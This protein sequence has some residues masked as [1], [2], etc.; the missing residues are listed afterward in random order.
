MKFFGKKK[1]PESLWRRFSEEGVILDHGQK[2]EK[3]KEPLLPAFLDQ[4]VDEGLAQER[5]DGCIIF[6]SDLYEALAKEE[7]ADLTKTLKLPPLTTRR[8]RLESRGALTDTDF[9]IFLTGWE[10]RTGAVLSSGGQ[11]ELMSAEAWRLFVAAREFAKRSERGELFQRQSWGTI[12]KLAVAAGASLDNFLQNTVVLTPEKLQISLEKIGQEPATADDNAAIVITPSFTDAPDG[13]LGRFDAFNAVQDRYDIATK[14]GIVQVLVTP[15]VKTVLREIKRLPKRRVR[16]ARARA[17]LINPMAALGDEAGAI[18]DI[19]Q[20]EAAR[21]EAGIFHECFQPIIER[22]HY[23]FPRRVGLV[24]ETLTDGAASSQTR[25]LSDEA[26]DEGDKKLRQFIDDLTDALEKNFPL[27]GWQG[28]E[29]ELSGEAAAHRD[30]LRAALTERRE[31][32]IRIRYEDIHNLANYIDRIEGI[33]Q[34]KAY[35]S[36]YIDPVGMGKPWIPDDP[37]III[38]VPGPDGQELSVLVPVNKEK[39]EELKEAVKQAEERGEQQITL[40]WLPRPLTREEAKEIIKTVDT[41]EPV[42]AP[43]NGPSG[44]DTTNTP[45]PTK[46][47]SLIIKPNINALDYEQRR[48]DVARDSL[49]APPRRAKSLRQEITL[50]PHQEA[51]LSWL[52][53]MRRERV[54]SNIH[55][56]IL[57]DDMGLGKTL[58][59]LAFMAQLLEDDSNIAPMLVVAPVALLENW[60]E[61]VKK[62]FAPDA[63]PILT[64]YGSDLSALRLS[65]AQIDARLRDEDGLNSFLKP[66]WADGAKIVLTTYETLRNLEFSFALQTWSVM[67]CDEAQKIKNPNALMTRAAKKQRAEFKIACTGTPVENT[68]ADLW[69][70]FDFIQPGLLGALDE[71]GKKYRKPIE[72]KTEEEKA[73]VEELRAKI[74]PQVLR[75]TKAEVAK[76]LPEKRVDDACRKLPLSDAQRRLYAGAINS[77]KQRGQAGAAT[78]FTNHLGLLHYLRLVCADP[79]PH[80]LTSFTPEPLAAYREKAPKLDWLLRQLTAIRSQEEKAIIFC[81]FKEIQRLLQHYIHESFGLRPPIINGETT[82]ATASSSSRQKQIHAFQNQAGFGVL[83]LSPLAVGFGV[84]IQA[85]NHVIHYSRAWNPAKEDQATDRAYR[86]GQKW[87]VHVYYPT[88]CADDFTTF[89]VRLN[90]LLE[91]KRDLAADMLNGA[92][93]IDWG[94][95][96]LTG[97][98][99]DGDAAIFNQRLTVDNIDAMEPRYFEALVA[100]IWTRRGFTCVLTP[101]AGDAGVDVVAIKGADGELIQVKKS[102]IGGQEQGWEAVKDVVAGEAVYQKKYPRITFTKIALTNQ[103]FSSTAKERARV[104]GVDLLERQAIDQFIQQYP[105]T[106][107]ELDTILARAK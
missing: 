60:R 69:C 79:K 68:L 57:A 28:Y 39:I 65:Q 18:L 85:A 64:A 20:I 88:V 98:A 87:D 89:D 12:R 56:V 51:G 52:Q 97:I 27:L 92:G 102:A 24:I 29:F 72:A 83:I 84:N 78:P 103:S 4:L 26:G 40:P 10:N 50:L 13:W 70:L 74:A 49:L 80:G 91:K 2:G 14:G 100:A 76:D 8:P 99:P 44:P 95:A 46:A 35:V 106:M 66:G 94:A 47:K 93:D 101:Q 42:V 22:D 58:Q 59:I 82:T 105:I 7:Y 67:V 63:F 43:P 30:I 61:E 48:R 6:W 34:E 17:I 37:I 81:E 31:P 41:A 11:E 32:H 53:G 107:I 1:S 3:L 25:W 45:E 71:F 21:R 96:D 62:F 36:I 55:G 90:E 77:F 38:V 16:G 19:E 75:R 23:G 5:Q 104:N 86:I 33:G 73:R 9:A 54:N 15:A